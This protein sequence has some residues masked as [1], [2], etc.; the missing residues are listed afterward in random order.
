[1]VS[2]GR[3]PG[4]DKKSGSGVGGLETEVEWNAP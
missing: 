1:M 2:L 3:D 4:T